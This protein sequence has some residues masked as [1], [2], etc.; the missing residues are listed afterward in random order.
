MEIS[1]LNSL[2][3]LSSLENIDCEL[4]HKYYKK[5]EEMLRLF[6]PILYGI[7][8]TAIAFEEPFQRA[9]ARL[10]CAVHELTKLLES[11]QLLSC[12]VHFVLQTE[13]LISKVRNCTLEIVELV[14]ASDQHLRAELSL[15]CLQ[16]CAQKMKSIDCEPLSTSINIATRD[17]EY[18]SDSAKNIANCLCLKS[19]QEFLIEL[20]ALEKLKENAAEGEKS[21][22][23]EQIIAVLTHMHDSFVRMEKFKKYSSLPLIPADFL[24]PLSLELMVDPVIV[25]SRCTY[26]RVFIQKWIGLGLTVCPKTRKTLTHV[27]FIPNYTSK[28]LISNWLEFKNIKLSN[29]MESSDGNI[30]RTWL[31]GPSSDAERMSLKSC[32][33]GM[34]NLEDRSLS[35]LSYH[36][37][38]SSVTVRGVSTYGSSQTTRS[39]ETDAST[40]SPCYSISSS[41]IQG[42]ASYPGTAIHGGN[43]D[44][45][46][47]SLQSFEGELVNTEDTSVIPL[48]YNPVRLFMNSL[49]SAVKYLYAS[50]G[51]TPSSLR[52]T[53]RS[54]GSV[55]YSAAIQRYAYSPSHLHSSSELSFLENAGMDVGWR[56]FQC[57]EDWLENSTDRNVYS[58]NHS[59]LVLS[60]NNSLSLS[61]S[62]RDF[63][64]LSLSRS[65]AASNNSTLSNLDYSQ[66]AIGDG[67]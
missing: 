41:V 3:H 6:M 54:S 31:Y 49:S 56:S 53:R 46:R 58:V 14:V 64:H 33:D 12:R 15:I 62:D 52:S 34:A 10:G 22:Y 21:E 17:A 30:S 18:I 40:G 38:H 25:G 66:A 36:S 7:L 65:S 27:N 35:S 5:T 61:S 19:N 26:E 51:S 60:N 9:F 2:F 16:H 37:M 11:W 67:H 8:D 63:F 20:V 59:P 39:Q 42:E 45:E 4:V 23:F 50:P 28:A 29:L 44:F 43:W 13:A 1:L 47:I 48:R 24:C 55:S 32:E 57:S